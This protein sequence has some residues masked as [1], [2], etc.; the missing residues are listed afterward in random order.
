MNV[1]NKTMITRQESLFFIFMASVGN[2]IY[3]LP[4]IILKTYR[5]SYFGIV[6]GISLLSLEGIWVLHISAKLNK[7][8]F[9]YLIEKGIGVI[10]C[11]ILEICFIAINIVLAITMLYIFTH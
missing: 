9:F 10:P 4:L 7:K 8:T 3:M 2:M 6:I 11:R 5:A 1:M